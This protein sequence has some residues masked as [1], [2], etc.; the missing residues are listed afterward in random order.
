MK[1]KHFLRVGVA[2]AFVALASHAKA[3]SVIYDNF[4]T[5]ET[6]VLNWAGDSLFT[7]LSGPATG[8]IANNASVD[9]VATGTYGIT[10]FDGVSNVVDLDGT[11]GSG[12][13][14]S[15]ILQSNTSLGSGD[16]TVTFWLSGNQRGG[17]AR[18]AT[19]S[20]GSDT[21]TS[22]DLASSAPWVFEKLYFTN[23]SGPVTFEGLGPSNDVGDLL[24]TV[25]VSTGVPEL[26]T[27]AMMGLGFAGLGFF[28]YRARKSLAVAR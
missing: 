12:N 7:S 17:P 25:T 4:T 9:L 28:S 18:E 3:T 20:I 21:W 15:G 16:Y 27:W 14:P 1:L 26:S 5:G 24:G 22:P 19:V 10:S 8:P 11:T 23:V 2:A 13:V 6:P